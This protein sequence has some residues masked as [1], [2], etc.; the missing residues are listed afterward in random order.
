M[1][2]LFKDGLISEAG[3]SRMKPESVKAPALGLQ[4]SREIDLHAGRRITWGMQYMHVCWTA[5]HGVLKNN[6]V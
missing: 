5:V 6:I 4:M 2:C 1:D 3:M